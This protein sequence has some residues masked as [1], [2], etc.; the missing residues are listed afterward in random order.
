MLSAPLRRASVTDRGCKSVPRT[1]G[2]LDSSYSSLVARQA[3]LMLHFEP[4]RCPWRWSAL[5]THR[6]PGGARVRLREKSSQGQDQLSLPRPTPPLAGH[7]SGRQPS[8]RAAGPTL[9]SGAPSQ[10]T[11]AR[12]RKQR[13]VVQV[14]FQSALEGTKGPYLHCRPEFQLALDAW[15]VL[16]VLLVVLEARQDVPAHIWRGRGI[17]ARALVSSGVSRIGTKARPPRQAPRFLQQPSFVST[18][19]KPAADAIINCRFCAMRCFPT[20]FS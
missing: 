5:F 14:G 19:S 18:S 20:A 15:L 9:E 16:L 2:L 4:R 11:P 10:C 7:E 1:Q 8:S 13:V 3:H 6:S 12:G 17:F